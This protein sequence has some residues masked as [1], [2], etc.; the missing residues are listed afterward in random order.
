VVSPADAIVSTRPPD[1][2]AAS[3]TAWS[4]YIRPNMSRGRRPA[5]SRPASHG[6]AAPARSAEPATGRAEPATEPAAGC[7]EPAT[8]PAAGCAEPAT[9]CA[10]PA[11]ECAEP[12][13]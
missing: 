11:T 4:S 9:G 10:E 8:E 13:E 12:T 3:S 1:A 5:D 2:N 6:L 7:A